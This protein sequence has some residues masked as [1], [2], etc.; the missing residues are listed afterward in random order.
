MPRSGGRS[1]AIWQKVRILSLGKL[2]Q[3]I[4]EGCRLTQGN[5]VVIYIKKSQ[6]VQL[7]CH[8]FIKGI[9]SLGRTV[10]VAATN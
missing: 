1:D 4:F 8:V 6:Y 7:L 10:S 9:R 3:L 5:A 2:L